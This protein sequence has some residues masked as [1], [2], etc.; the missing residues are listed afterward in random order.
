MAR[1]TSWTRSARGSPC[2]SDWTACRLIPGA[3]ALGTFLALLATLGAAATAV[4]LEL[5]QR[6]VGAGQPFCLA[7]AALVATVFFAIRLRRVISK[8]VT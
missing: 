6:G 4:D 8:P 7:A 2:T 1:A 3:D 5:S